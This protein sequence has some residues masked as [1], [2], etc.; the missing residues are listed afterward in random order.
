MLGDKYTICRPHSHVILNPLSI[1]TNTMLSF[2]SFL[3][4]KKTYI[5][6]IIALVVIGA[7]LFGFIDVNTA[8]NILAF[9]FPTGLMTL[10]AGQTR[11]EN[12]LDGELRD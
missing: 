1:N 4:G 12:K 11:I 6:S 8:N 9:L 5:V 7:H 10:K 2:L 3:Q